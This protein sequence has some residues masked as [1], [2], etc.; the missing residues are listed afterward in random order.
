M[1]Y[2]PEFA[3][4]A[5]LAPDGETPEQKALRLQML[6]AQLRNGTAPPPAAVKPEGSWDAPA[7]AAAAVPTKAEI[8]R[9][10]L[11]GNT[12]AMPPAARITAQGVA[13][14]TPEFNAQVEGPDLN[15]QW[16]DIQRQIAEAQR[17]MDTAGLVEAG[18][19][20]GE[21]GNMDMMLALAAQGAGSD[22]EGLSGTMLKRAMAARDPMAFTGGTVDYEGNVTED[23]GF[24]RAET[25]KMLEGRA[26]GLEKTIAQRQAQQDAIRA[27]AEQ[28]TRDNDLRAQIASGN[29]QIAAILAGD[30]V[31]RTRQ[32]T[33]A[34]KKLATAEAQKVQDSKDAV[35]LIDEAARILPG[36]THSGIGNL[37][38]SAAGA[39]GVSTAGAE[40]GDKLRVIGGYLTSK[41]PRMQGPQSDYDVKLY[42]EMA[43][44]VGDTSLPIA[45]RQAALATMKQLHQGYAFSPE[46]DVPIAGPGG[47]APAAGGGGGGGGWT[48]KIKGQ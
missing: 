16:K 4:S 37:V 14:G 48:V 34:D 2:D 22:F 42:Q 27:K 10:S 39:I 35:K 41:V 6:K 33:A 47:A 17:P 5:F 38:D 19:R 36:S 25:I 46:S 3:A 24:K 32:G 28:T 9:S 30:R 44:R 31:E 18:K 1:A 20:R 45:R 7:A 40:A 13:P 26:G 15:A 8:I 43:G 23:P 11:R 29:Q 21:R 12:A